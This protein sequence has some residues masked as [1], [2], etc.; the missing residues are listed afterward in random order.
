M[1]IVVEEFEWK[2]KLVKQSRCECTQLKTTNSKLPTKQIRFP[3]RAVKINLI[4]KVS[5]G[6]AIT[7]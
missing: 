3:V 7:Q 4:K 1:L 6:N 5:F 2:L